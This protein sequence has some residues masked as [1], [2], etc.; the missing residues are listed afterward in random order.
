VDSTGFLNVILPPIP[1]VKVG[2][3]GWIADGDEPFYIDAEIAY[4]Y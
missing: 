4:V 3:H 2:N 1:V